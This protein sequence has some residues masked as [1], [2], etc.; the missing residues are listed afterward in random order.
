MI[1]D[2][3][4]N[5]RHA[6]NQ[7]T[8]HWIY[9]LVPTLAAIGVGSYIWLLSHNQDLLRQ[10]QIDRAAIQQTQH[11]DAKV[12][13]LMQE[14]KELKRDVIQGKAELRAEKAANRQ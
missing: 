11:L 12:Q 1:P 3:D 2:W 4:H 9:W 10:Q 5:T 13:G 6:W 8:G 14:V 7:L